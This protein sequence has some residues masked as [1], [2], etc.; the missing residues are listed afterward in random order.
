MK[1]SDRAIENAFRGR[2]KA[3]LSFGFAFRAR[4]KANLSFGRHFRG[5]ENENRTLGRR[6]LFCLFNNLSIE[7]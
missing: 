3:I 1:K 2:E 7:C 5:R 4:E 6:I